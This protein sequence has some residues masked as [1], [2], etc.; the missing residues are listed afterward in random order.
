MFQV[1]SETS[2]WSWCRSSRK[3]VRIRSGD[4]LALQRLELVLHPRLLGGEEPIAV[5]LTTTRRRAARRGSARPRPRASR[6][7]SGVEQNT[8]QRTSR[9]FRSESE[10]EQRPAAADLD[11]VG[12]GAER[13]DP[14]GACPLA[15]Q[16]QAL[17]RRRSCGPASRAAPF[18]FQTSQGTWPRAYRSSSSC[19]SLN[20]SMQAQKPS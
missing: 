16:R 14:P 11:V 18:A 2:R 7:R 8:T 6:A 10:P 15:E 1:S 5:R 17:H 12:V 20:V 19:F 3:W 13:E 9:S 4:E